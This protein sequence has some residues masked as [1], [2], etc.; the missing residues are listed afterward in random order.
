MPI[1]RCMARHPQIMAAASIRVF[2][3]GCFMYVYL[4]VAA[5][6]AW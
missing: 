2:V 5:G 3:N 6:K 1:A 4:M